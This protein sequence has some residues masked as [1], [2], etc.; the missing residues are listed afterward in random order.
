MLS[1]RAVPM[2]KRDLRQIVTMPANFLT[3]S[4]TAYGKMH[5]CHIFFS[6][7]HECLELKAG[8]VDS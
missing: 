4:P 1:Y 2:F 3:G 7:L 8:S 5:S 6:F